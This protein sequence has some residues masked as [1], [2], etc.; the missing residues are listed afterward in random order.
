MPPGRLQRPGFLFAMQRGRRR[1]AGESLRETAA[2]RG[3][4]FTASLPVFSALPPPGET[5]VETQVKTQV[6]DSRL[7][8]RAAPRALEKFAARAPKRSKAKC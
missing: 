8:P 7:T 3:G 2:R 1:S 6:S 5:Q 4:G